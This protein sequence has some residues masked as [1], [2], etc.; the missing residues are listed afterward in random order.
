[1][2]KIIGQIVIQGKNYIDPGTGAMIVQILIAGLISC[3]VVF[4]SR[5][6][7]LFNKLRR[8]K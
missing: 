1:M 5:V 3:G 6:L 4:R 2:I 7:W 8:R